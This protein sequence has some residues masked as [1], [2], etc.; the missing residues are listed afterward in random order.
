MLRKS[1]KMWENNWE[2]E[3]KKIT[4]S[5]FYISIGLLLISLFVLFTELLVNNH[6][7]FKGFIISKR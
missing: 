7:E 2:T 1:Q 4:G 5:H 3:Y 6:L